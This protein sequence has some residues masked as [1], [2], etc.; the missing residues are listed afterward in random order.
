MTFRPLA[1]A[2]LAATLLAGCHQ[3]GPASAAAARGGATS[4]LATDYQL[5]AEERETLE[6][7]LQSLGPSFADGAKAAPT[8]GK[9]IGPKA[10]LLYRALAR[11]GLMRRAA[12]KLAEGPVHKH[13]SKPGT[14]DAIPPLSA[15]ERQ[16]LDALLQ[17]GDVIQCGNDGSFVHAIF[18][19]GEGMIV[20]ALAQSGFG[21]KMIGV[22]REKL[23]EYLDRVERDKVVVLRPRWT[24]ETLDAAVA[25]AK[26]Q[27][28]KDYDPLFMT[29]A[30]DRHYCTELIW[31][32]VTRTGAA[33]VEPHLAGKVHWRLV[34][35]EDIRASQDLTV[36]WRR[37]HD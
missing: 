23:A 17:P 37:N 9:D 8:P 15:A 28:G 6:Q 34:T 22:R 1:A 30:D 25:Y 27:V 11:N 18:Y 24:P 26:A 3:A 21:K 7:V 33:R 4:A 31:A 35:N 29:D 19:E 10:G 16:E 32:I 14:K 20:H 36:V 5:T 2:L 12:A 13:F